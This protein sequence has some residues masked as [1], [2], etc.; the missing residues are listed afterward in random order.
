MRA[1]Y[2]NAKTW[3]DLG[4]AREPAK[5]QWAKVRGAFDVLGELK[6]VAR[7]A[8]ANAAANDQGATLA[9]APAAEEVSENQRPMHDAGNAGLHDP[10]QLGAQD[11]EQAPVADEPAGHGAEPIPVQKEPE[12]QRAFDVAN[13]LVAEAQAAAENVPKEVRG[14]EVKLEEQVGERALRPRVCCDAGAAA[15]GR[16]AVHVRRRHGCL[17]ATSPGTEQVSRAGVFAPPAHGNTAVAATR[18]LC[19]ALSAAGNCSFVTAGCSSCWTMTPR[20]A[21]SF[22]RHS[23]TTVTE[24]RM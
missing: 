20:G 9:Q 5:K 16:C 10:L 17:H 1:Q 15:G 4:V 24:M 12:C 7:A 11:D 8:E 14:G 23:C 21:S 19:C 3:R 22:P 18:R 2:P 13:A 6:L